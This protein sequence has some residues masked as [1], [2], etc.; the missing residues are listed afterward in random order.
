MR[1][2]TQLKSRAMILM[3]PIN[4]LLVTRLG[5]S[6]KVFFEK[7]YLGFLA[8]KNIDWMRQTCR[9]ALLFANRH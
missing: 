9:R 5:H 3:T 2:R 6:I 8:S 7:P 4:W 1:N